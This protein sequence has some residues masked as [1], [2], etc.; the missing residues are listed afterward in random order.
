MRDE[1]VSGRVLLGLPMLLAVGAFACGG[2]SN[3]GAGGGPSRTTRSVMNPTGDCATSGDGSRAGHSPDATDVYLSD[4]ESTLAR[5]YYRVFVKADDT[6]YMIP[7]PDGPHT[8][9]FLPCRAEEDSP[10]SSAGALL[11]LP[12][13]AAHQ[14][15]GRARQCAGASGRAQH[16]ARAQRPARLL[17]GGERVAVGFRRHC[18]AVQGRCGL[19]CWPRRNAATS[20]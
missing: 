11:A 1:R 8:A 19:S 12:G 9:F 7:R 14:R 17:R 15:T 3:P 4:C 20:S 2:E 16:R 5:E 18:G 10:S 13:G 6:A